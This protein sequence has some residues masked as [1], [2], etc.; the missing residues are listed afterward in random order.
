MIHHS[1]QF[2]STLKPSNLRDLPEKL[3]STSFSWLK[4]KGDLQWPNPKEMTWKTRKK[5]DFRRKGENDGKIWIII[6]KLI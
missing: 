3:I 5:Q 1:L 6:S 2:H 4:K